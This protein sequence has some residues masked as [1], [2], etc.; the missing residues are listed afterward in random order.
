MSAFG[1]LETIGYVGSIEAIN[2]MVK[3]S[4]V[5]VV[6]QF[7]SGGGYV[8][9]VVRGDVGSVK[10]AVDAGSEATKSIG[11]LVSAHVIPRPHNRLIE[12]F[13]SEED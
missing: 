4:N 2:T 10:S 13:F 11:V 6:G 7:Q 3:A 8:T 9:V 5:E 1:F 12:V